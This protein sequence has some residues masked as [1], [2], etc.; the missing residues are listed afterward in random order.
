[1]ANLFT[2][3]QQLQSNPSFFATVGDATEAMVQIF[4]S[5]KSNP[6]ASTGRKLQSL[7]DDAVKLLVRGCHRERHLRVGITWHVWWFPDRLRNDDVSNVSVAY[8]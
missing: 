2:L 8:P 3:G 1:M 4:V 5:L 7:S 6:L